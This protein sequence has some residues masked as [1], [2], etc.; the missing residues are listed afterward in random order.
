MPRLTRRVGAAALL[1]AGVALTIAGMAW[2]SQAD[3]TSG[4][5]AAVS[6][7]MLLIRAGQGLALRP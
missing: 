4:Y 7:P 6:V 2:L 3:A 5:L 1:A